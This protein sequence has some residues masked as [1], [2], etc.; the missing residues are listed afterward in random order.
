MKTISICSAAAVCLFAVLATPA[1]AA[2]CHPAK[3]D[4]VDV[5]QKNAHARAETALQREI[6]ALKTSF[7]AAGGQ[8]ARPVAPSV[9]CKP[10]PNL[11]GADE[12]EC[13]GEAKVCVTL[14]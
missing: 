13:F 8:I 2:N 11:L 10:Y 3:S 12:W 14:K 6:E 4:V 1:V 9:T 5:G 7:T